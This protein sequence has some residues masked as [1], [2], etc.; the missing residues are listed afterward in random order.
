VLAG[1]Q[2]SEVRDAPCRRAGGGRGGAHARL[3]L[4]QSARKLFWQ[5][6]RHPR[7][8]RQS[9]VHGLRGVGARAAGAGA[10]LATRVRQRALAGVAA[11]R[12]L[13]MN[14]VDKLILSVKRQ[15]NAVSKAAHDVYRWLERWRVPQNDMTKLF[16]R[17]LYYAHDAYEG[18]REMLAGKLL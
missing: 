12:R 13:G 2:R 10:V 1:A 14:L 16:Y 11:R 15:D 7:R 17:T 9:G 8:R 4:G 3:R 18:G 5:D 6:L